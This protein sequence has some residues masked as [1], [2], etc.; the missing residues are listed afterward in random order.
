MPELFPLWTVLKTQ[1]Q[2]NQTSNLQSQQA[3][4]QK[5]T[6]AFPAAHKAF[7][8]TTFHKFLDPTISVLS[9]IIL[10]QVQCND[11]ALD[12]LECFNH[13]QI[14]SRFKKQQSMHQ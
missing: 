13:N 6:P 4:V 3:I 12:L 10:K 2:Q 5:C 8:Q 14:E 1:K 11:K 9:V 7:L